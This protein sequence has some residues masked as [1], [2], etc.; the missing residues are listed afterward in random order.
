MFKYDMLVLRNKTRPRK[1][2]MARL[3]TVNFNR[4]LKNL[5]RHLRKETE[6]EYP[7]AS[8]NC[9]NIAIA[10]SELL[11]FYEVEHNFVLTT[12]KNNFSNIGEINENTKW[13]DFKK[14]NYSGIHI[15]VEV[16]GEILDFTCGNIN[17]QK[18]F[19]EQAN[20]RYFNKLV[21]YKVYDFDM[22]GLSNYIQ[23]HCCPW[24]TSNN[25]I[26][27]LKTRHK[28]YKLIND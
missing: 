1:Y 27:L 18:D 2:L 5:N 14:E 8:G 9:G 22:T 4:M 17:H 6:R 25:F 16:N 13:E 10:V 21:N 24:I 15:A 23:K 28:R 11:K 12:V 20:I 19:F 7:L 26:E 3:N